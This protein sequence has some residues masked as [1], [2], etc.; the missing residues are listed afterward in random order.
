M[1]FV[2]DLRWKLEI[3]TKMRYAYDFC[4]KISQAVT[5]D[6]I[7][8]KLAETQDDLSLFALNFLSELQLPDGVIEKEKWHASVSLAEK[9]VFDS[10]T[11]LLYK[12]QN[13]HWVD[14][15]EE[16]HTRISSSLSEAGDDLT[17]E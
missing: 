16:T 12:Q 10:L 9:H 8:S 6:L 2:A 17:L 4:S 13:P 14:P 7:K 1:A 11:N 3:F 15:R 5:T